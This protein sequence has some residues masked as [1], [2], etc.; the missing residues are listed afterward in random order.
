MPPYRLPVG[1]A[2]KTVLIW[3]VSTG[4]ELPFPFPFPLIL[5]PFPATTNVALPKAP[6][7]FGLPG[8]PR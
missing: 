8:P 6:A 5:L 1:G 4:L 3:D 7:R 2:A